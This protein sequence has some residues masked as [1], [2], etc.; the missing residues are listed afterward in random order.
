MTGRAGLQKK[1]RVSGVQITG[2]FYFE[3]FMVRSKYFQFDTNLDGSEEPRSEKPFV[4]G[5]SSSGQGLLG[6]KS[7]STPSP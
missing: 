7:T 1:L 6:V 2:S 4:C 3:I 5:Q